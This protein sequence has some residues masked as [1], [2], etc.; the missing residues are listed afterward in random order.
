MKDG[1]EGT[2]A[3][4]ILNEAERNQMF[5]QL[6]RDKAEEFKMLGYDQVTGQDIWECVS[7]KYYK[8]GTPPLHAVVNDIMSLKVNQ[9][10]N[11]IT[12]SLYRGEKR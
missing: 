7:D 10:M 9:Y 1:E 2:G 12:L 5:E 8:T 6:C 3:A 4:D 11:F